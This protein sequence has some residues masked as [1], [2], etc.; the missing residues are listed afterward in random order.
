MNSSKRSHSQR[1][2]QQISFIITFGFCSL[3]KKSKKPFT[4]LLLTDNIKLDGLPTKIKLKIQGCFTLYFNLWEGTSVK[5][6]KI[7]LPVLLFV[8]SHQ[9][10]YQQISLF[11]HLFRTS[12]N[13]LWKRF[14][15]ANLLLYRIHPNPLNSQNILSLTKVFCQFSLKC[16]LNFFKK[17]LS[18][19][20]YKSILYVSAVN[21]Y[22][23]YIF[24][25]SN[26]RFSGVLFRTYFKNSY[27]NTSICN[28]L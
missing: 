27:F 24:K 16:F 17:Y 8:V 23:T 13:I 2:S 28:Y 25:G 18:T 3:S 6:Y 22:C 11:L 9:F 19:K 10:L 12:F 21:C 5:S 14:F 4:P 7:Q 15:I 1:D 26:Y 20:S